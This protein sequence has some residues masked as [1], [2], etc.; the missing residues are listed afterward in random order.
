MKGYP[1]FILLLL[2]SMPA[3]SDA[4]FNCEDL[5]GTW[6]SSNFEY[7][8]GS[9]KTFETIFYEDSTFRITFKFAS[10]LG[11]ESQV[12]SGTWDC[13]GRFVTMY[14]EKVGDAD[15][16]Y[17]ERYRLIELNSTYCKYQL[18]DL[19]DVD[20]EHVIGDCEATIYE[21]IKKL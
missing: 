12:E 4:L 18:I 19:E 17:K 11:V 6:Q 21:G 9:Q 15:A 14:T 1:A 5:V 8:I 13:D 3:S 7:T 10:S 16:A 20:C 2:L